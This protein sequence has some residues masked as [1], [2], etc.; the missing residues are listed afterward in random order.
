MDVGVILASVALKAGS[1]A[2]IYYN[3]KLKSNEPFELPTFL[4]GLLGA[5]VV[6]LIL[7]I[8]GLDIES[9]LNLIIAS[10]ISI[11]YIGRNIAKPIVDYIIKKGE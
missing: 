4:Y 8:L 9:N 11:E 5:G 2:L 3:K 7:A 6:G 10:S 1:G